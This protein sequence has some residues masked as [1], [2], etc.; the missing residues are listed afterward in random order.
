MMRRILMIVTFLGGVFFIL[1]PFVGSTSEPQTVGD[2]SKAA[3]VVSLLMGLFL[4]IV[5]GYHLVKSFRSN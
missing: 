2:H 1:I 5:S 4:A 3:G